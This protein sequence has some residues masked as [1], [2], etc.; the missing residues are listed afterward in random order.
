MG[1]LGP[2]IRPDG[3]GLSSE[4]SIGVTIN[5]KQLEIPTIVPTLTSDEL[6]FLLTQDY[7]G[8]FKMPQGIVQKA[9]EFAKQRLAEGKALFAQSGEEQMNVHP[10]IRRAGQNPEQAR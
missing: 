9:V 3:S 6:K 10:Q 8:G 7:H 1:F 5:G 4:I 2:L